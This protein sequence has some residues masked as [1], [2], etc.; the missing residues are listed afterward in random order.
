MFNAKDV[1]DV[2]KKKGRKMIKADKQK[3]LVLPE[4]VNKNTIKL[5]LEELRPK[6]DPEEKRKIDRDNKRFEYE[7]TY[8]NMGDNSLQ[9]NTQTMQVDWRAEQ[10]LGLLIWMEIL[11]HG[12]KTI[13]ELAKTIDS[14][15][16]NLIAIV[17][18]TMIKDDLLMNY[19]EKDGTET[20]ELVDINEKNKRRNE[21]IALEDKRYKNIEIDDIDVSP[22]PDS[23]V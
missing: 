2:R 3:K 15:N 14:V 19:K 9:I 8:F 11:N 4:G 13:D 12:R 16:I 10:D 6:D 1:M 7:G 17:A 5:F 18:N 21:R 22:D 23:M 20:L